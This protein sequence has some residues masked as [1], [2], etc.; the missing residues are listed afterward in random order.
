VLVIIL[1]A[2]TAVTIYK[3]VQMSK[4][5]AIN[6]YRILQLSM[7]ILYIVIIII[8]S[9]MKFKDGIPLYNYLIYIYV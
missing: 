6:V 2:I 8:T 5:K 9:F 7:L 3:F 1:A 4:E